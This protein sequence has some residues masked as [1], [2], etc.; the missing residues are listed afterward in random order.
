MSDLHDRLRGFWDRD[1]QIYDSSPSHALTD[2]VE[3]SVWRAVLARHLPIE[4]SSVLDV[5]AGTGAMSLLA[6]ELGHRVTALDLSPVMLSRAREKAEARGFDL[7]TVVGSGDEP[8]AGPFDAVIERHVL[9][10]TPEPVAALE[11]WRKV[12]PTGRLILFE[13]LFARDS[14][15]WRA[16]ETAAGA[17]QRLLGI[18]S[19]H[20]R[21]YEADLIASLPLA[22]AMSP[23]PLV[24][25]VAQA[26]WRRIRIER[27]RDVEWARRMASH[28]LLGRLQAVPQFALVAEA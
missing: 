4:A 25:S 28:W 24:R 10:T 21:H 13:G 5:G 11:A 1:A 14:L 12:A 15:S 23:A 6:A 18:P 16:R 3:A 19:G 7:V 26:G 17:V 27:L 8:P 20:H 22:R 2:P 9:W